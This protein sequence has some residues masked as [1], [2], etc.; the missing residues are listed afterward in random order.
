MKTRSIISLIG[1]SVL[2]WYD[3]ALLGTLTPVIAQAFFPSTN[4]IAS[5]LYAYATFAISFL[6][7]PLG[8]LLFGHIGD[9]L[10]R[11]RVLTL[12]IILMTIP[13]ALIAVLPTYHDIGIT[14]SIL[15]IILRLAQGLAA[16]PEFSAA[17]IFMV[18][19][20]P[21][22]KQAF[23]G[24]LSTLG[25]SLGMILGGFVTW[26]V[27]VHFA[28]LAWA[29]R[30]PFALSIVG[31][32]I[33]FI[34]RLYLIEPLP[35]RTR[36]KLPIANA[37]KHDKK[38]CLIAAGAAWYQGVLAYGIFVW[39]ITYLHIFKH[40]PLSQTILASTLCLAANAISQPFFGTLADSI[41]KVKHL[42]IGL[43]VALIGL[44]SIMILLKY[45]NGLTTIMIGM[46]LLGLIIAFA[47]APLNALAI[48]QFKPEHR[49]SGFGV[50]FNIVMALIGGTTPLMLTALFH[51]NETLVL[52]YFLIAIGIGYLMSRLIHF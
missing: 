20:A 19:S 3:F 40:L 24:S 16:S 11:K 34:L 36:V 51:W 32:I 27:Y 44:V 22:N 46:V 12:T 1:G 10:G 31:G 2:Q 23:Y 35:T 8:A 7:A 13:T 25:Y 14:A 43:V 41:G 5:L 49:M 21:K 9:R 45:S 29:W 39:S 50:S 48:L 17:S 15:L 47:L 26:Q 37:F 6:L 33:V 28:Y 42:R 30:I 18:E 4:E 52:V 38:A